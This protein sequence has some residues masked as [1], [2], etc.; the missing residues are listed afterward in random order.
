MPVVAISEALRVIAQLVA[1]V[2]SSSQSGQ[3]IPKAEFDAAVAS[4]N[5]ALD[6]LD[7][8][9]ERAKGEGR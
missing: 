9:I 1:L 6:K 8:S 3:P 7:A 2:Q 4:R 5:A